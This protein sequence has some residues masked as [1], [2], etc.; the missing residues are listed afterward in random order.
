MQQCGE[1]MAL[2]LQFSAC[3]CNYCGT[4]RVALLVP[5]DALC[6][7]N[8]HITELS[9]CSWRR[10]ALSCGR[11]SKMKSALLLASLAA[12]LLAASA[13]TSACVI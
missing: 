8:S 3:L 13:D 2:Q 9:L 7:P 12:L 11:P 5:L 4:Q 6:R 10:L 1:L